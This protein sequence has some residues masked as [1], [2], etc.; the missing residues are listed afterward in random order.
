MTTALAHCGVL[1]RV[2]DSS[3]TTVQRFRAFVGRLDNA[4]VVSGGVLQLRVELGS[5]R[6]RE[7]ALR[8]DVLL[9]PSHLGSHLLEGEGATWAMQQL[10]GVA[11]KELSLACKDHFVRLRAPVTLALKRRTDA[12]TPRYLSQAFNK[13]MLKEEW[14]LVTWKR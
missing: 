1:T 12:S 6:R 9:E 2:T 14:R 8:A 3:M 5:S 4:S 13:A 11:L 10:C 7:Q